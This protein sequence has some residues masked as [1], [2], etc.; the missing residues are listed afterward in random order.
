MANIVSTI[1]ENADDLYAALAKLKAPDPA[2]RRANAQKARAYLSQSVAGC[3]DQESTDIVLD[4]IDAL[5]WQAQARSPAQIIDDG[6]WYLR[7]LRDRLQRQFVKKKGGLHRKTKADY[8]KQ[9]FAD[10]DTLEITQTLEQFGVEGITVTPYTK[11]WW[12][13]EA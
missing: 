7:L 8:Q 11:N 2:Q 10:T 4:A 3:L 12:R 6:R 5:N 9:K 13:L 1:H